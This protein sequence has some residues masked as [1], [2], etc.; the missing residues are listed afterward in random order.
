[1]K[2][3]EL[4]DAGPEIIEYLNLYIENKVKLLKEELRDEVKAI[5]NKYKSYGTNFK[6]NVKKFLTKYNATSD[7]TWNAVEAIYMDVHHLLEE[8]FGMVNIVDFG[9]TKS[10]IKSFF[11]DDLPTNLAAK[12]K[13]ENEVFLNLAGEQIKSFLF[14][15]I[16]NLPVKYIIKLITDKKLNI[17]NNLI[18]S[19]KYSQL[20]YELERR[21]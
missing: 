10:T 20:S 3:S 8:K 12:K 7:F 18:E 5:L 15:I 14:H 19:I 17:K 4:L 2:I 13:F 16:K 1:M 6:Q 9:L 11:S 21:S